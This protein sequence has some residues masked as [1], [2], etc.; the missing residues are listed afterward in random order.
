MLGVEYFLLRLLGNGAA[1]ECCAVPGRGCVAK[2]RKWSFITE[3]VRSRILAHE[4]ENSQDR[5]WSTVLD[6]LDQTPYQET[7]FQMAHFVK[8]TEIRK[9]EGITNN[10]INISPSWPMVVR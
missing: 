7:K 4:G 3:L 9:Y 6:S 5:P 2:S 1:K 10:K 8:L